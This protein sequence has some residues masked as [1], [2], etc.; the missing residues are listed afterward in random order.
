M[1]DVCYT[2]TIEAYLDRLQTETKV[3]RFCGLP[4]N[5]GI[6][7]SAVKQNIPAGSFKFTKTVEHHKHHVFKISF[8]RDHVFNLSQPIAVKL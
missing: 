8:L 1:R 2:V 5:V 7:H 4:S 3:N 6:Q